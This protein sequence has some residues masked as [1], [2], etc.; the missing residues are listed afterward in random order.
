MSQSAMERADTG[1]PLTA[2]PGMQGRVVAVDGVWFYA[3]GCVLA[4][5]GEA[6][7][8]ACRRCG[9]P[10]AC[11]PCRESITR[12]V[13]LGQRPPAGQVALEFERWGTP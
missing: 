1:G 10:T 11:A 12:Q 13:W 2:P 4:F 7:P 3:D 8:A 6:Y 9:R 5:H